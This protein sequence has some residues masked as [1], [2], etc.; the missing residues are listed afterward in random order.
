MQPQPGGPEALVQLRAVK[1]QEGEL[2]TALAESV[3]HLLLC[4]FK[5]FNTSTED[6]REVCKQLTLCASLNAA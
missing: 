3:H 6:P 5:L 4:S 1:A 2:S